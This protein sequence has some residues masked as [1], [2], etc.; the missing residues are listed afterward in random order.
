MHV[1]RHIFAAVQ[2]RKEKENTKQEHLY[3]HK[4]GWKRFSHLTAHLAGNIKSW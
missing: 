3:E 4:Q 2:N 1:H